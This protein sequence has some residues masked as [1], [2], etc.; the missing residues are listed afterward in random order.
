MI[1]DDFVRLPI[2]GTLD[3]H[4]FDPRDARAV[5]LDYVDAAHA[6][7][8]REIRIVHGRGRGV[9]RGLVQASLDTHPLVE[10]FWD[11]H[12]SHLGATVARLTEDRGRGPGI[13]DRL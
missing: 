4:T 8:L 13:G 7:G 3:L 12:D 5:V 2:D 1:G 9:L 10:A 6:G 11:D